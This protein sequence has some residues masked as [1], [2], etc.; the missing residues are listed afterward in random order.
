M[1]Y[2]PR[3]GT[4]R[5]YLNCRHGLAPERGRWLGSLFPYR[6]PRRISRFRLDC[7]ALRFLSARRMMAAQAQRSGW[8]RVVKGL[9][10]DPATGIRRHIHHP[11]DDGFFRHCRGRRRGAAL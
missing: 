3:P 9:W 5:H 10:I 1:R 11:K 4:T 7:E 8:R 2:D 6:R